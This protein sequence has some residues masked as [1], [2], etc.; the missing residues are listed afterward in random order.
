MAAS[1]TRKRLEQEAAG[2]KLDALFAEN[3]GTIW[4]SG[5]SKR[6][7]EQMIN[8]LE[9]SAQTLQIAEA[10]AADIVRK[11]DSAERPEVVRARL[12][13]KVERIRVGSNLAAVRASIRQLK[14]N[15]RKIGALSE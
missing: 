6:A 14:A 1:P 9:Q 11:L 2:A 15:N 13:A 7:T 4:K 10:H 8:N 3:T 12:L 5:F